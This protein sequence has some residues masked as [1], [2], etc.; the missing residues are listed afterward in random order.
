MEPQ[1]MVINTL[2]R[3]FA[4]YGIPHELRTDGGPQFTAKEFKNFT[5]MFDFEHI[6]SSPYYLKS[7]GLTEKGVQVIKGLLKKAG[8]SK[9]EF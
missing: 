8:T 6:I 4:R 3:V 9:E 1:Q 5:V 2:S 7:N